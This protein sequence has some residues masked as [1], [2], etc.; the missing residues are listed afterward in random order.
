MCTRLTA[1]KYVVALHLG[2]TSATVW[3]L[4]LNGFIG[5]QWAEDGTAKSLWVGF[6]F[7]QT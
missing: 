6:Y 2:L 7:I 4:F 3:V 5:F 1:F